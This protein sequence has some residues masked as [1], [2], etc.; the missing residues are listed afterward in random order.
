MTGW[1]I[2]GPVQE[3]TQ[4]EKYTTLEQPWWANDYLIL[5]L[6]LTNIA[7]IVVDM[8]Q[9][10][11]LNNLSLWW[12]LVIIDFV[13]VLF[14][15]LDL[16]EDYGRCLDKKWWWKTH[17]WEFLGLVPMVFA[18]IPFLS[19]GLGLR[20]LRLVRAFSGVLR[21]IG[22]TQ[23]A[24][25]VTVER[26]IGHLFTIVFTLIIAG[27]FFV[28]VF[29]NQ[30]YIELCVGLLTPPVG[31]NRIIHDFPTSVWW[32]IVTTTTVGYGD[33][34]P[35]TI[36]GRIIA[37]GLMLVGIG[38]VGTLAATFS[39]LFYS[40]SGGGGEF[41]SP[42][43]T[44]NDPIELLDRLTQK[45]SERLVRKKD[46][47][48]ALALIRARTAAELHALRYEIDSI[49]TLPLPLQIAAK[50]ELGGR[51]THLEEQMD[52]VEQRILATEEE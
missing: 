40:T 30:R 32:A 15:F 4:D 50:M 8:E 39:Q 25:E 34:T 10:L 41:G 23:R 20:F 38:L 49:T 26:Q 44:S 46:F 5:V 45:R 6:T 48:A 43:G 51:M 33:H 35:V 52:E 24:T 42:V 7:I 1:P 37:S 19:A 2:V 29:E 18:L 14:F 3:E 13:M 11:Y 22:A 12:K 9:N 28:Y 21:L 47:E 27:A 31:C 16:L 17:G 36:P